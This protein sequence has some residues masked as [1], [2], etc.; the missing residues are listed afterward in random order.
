MTI[1]MNWFVRW[2]RCFCYFH[3]YIDLF[4]FHIYNSLYSHSVVLQNH[5][6]MNVVE[7][8]DELRVRINKEGADSAVQK[9][10]TLMK[11]FKVNF[12]YFQ[13]I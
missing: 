4:G 6:K 3:F 10:Y 9:L 11:S 1:W 12:Y 2:I 7:K 5:R 8:L 13:L